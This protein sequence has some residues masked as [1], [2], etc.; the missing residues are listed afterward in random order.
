[1]WVFLIQIILNYMSYCSQFQ[2]SQFRRAP[3]GTLF[4]VPTPWGTSELGEDCFYRPNRVQANHFARL[5]GRAVL[6]SSPLVLIFPKLRLDG[7]V[8]TLSHR[9]LSRIG[10]VGNIIGRGSRVGM[11]EP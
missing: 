6:V 11:G 8:L 3:R 10:G 5:G 4:N 7:Q 9:A 2:W 1:M